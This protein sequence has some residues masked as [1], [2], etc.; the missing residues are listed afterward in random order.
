MLYQSTL[1]GL[2][3]LSTVDALHIPAFATRSGPIAMGVHETITSSLWQTTLGAEGIWQGGAAGGSAEARR[4]ARQAADALTGAS[5]AATQM[6]DLAAD[7]AQGFNTACVELSKEDQAKKDWLAK[8]DVPE[9]G[10]AATAVQHVAEAMIPHPPSAETS[11][12]ED[13][14]AAWLARLD[15]PAWGS[16]AKAINTIA[17]EAAKMADL[18]SACESNVESACV[19]LSKEDAAKKEWLAKLEPTSW[20]NVAATV[21]TAFAAS[22]AEQAAKAKWLQSLDNEPSWAANRAAPVEETLYGSPEVP[23]DEASAKAAWLARLDLPAFGQGKVVPTQQAAP[24]A[25]VA[26]PV[27]EDSAKAAW[28]ARLDVPAWGANKEEAPAHLTTAPIADLSAEEAAKA[29][30]IQSLDTRRP[31]WGPR[32][33][34]PEAPAE[35]DSLPSPLSAVGFVSPSR[36]IVDA[37]KAAWLAKADQ[38][39]NWRRA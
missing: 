17:A 30:W 39:M 8:L 27:G 11:S 33:D 19:E 25:P 10:A 23:S 15:T 14:K 22:S 28:L 6:A 36:K 26:S 16:A 9:W 12:L 35:A 13:A 7:C 18:T 37:S 5:V 20:G 32:D 21:S 24:V 4:A 38:V 29:K 34:V 2:G 31:S 1:L 3:L